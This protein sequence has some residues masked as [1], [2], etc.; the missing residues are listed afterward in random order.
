MQRILNLDGPF[1]SG[2]DGALVREDSRVEETNFEMIIRI[3]KR[4]RLFIQGVEAN[5]VHPL[6]EMIKGTM[7]L[8]QFFLIGVVEGPL[9]HFASLDFQMSGL[10]FIVHN[11]NVV[12]YILYFLFSCFCLFVCKANKI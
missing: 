11:A 7:I 9:D 3:F 4:V 12:N 1:H 5:D 8:I 6:L 2:V 10:K